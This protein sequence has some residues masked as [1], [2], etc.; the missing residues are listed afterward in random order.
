MPLR[1]AL[2]DALLRIA[3][4]RTAA[5]DDPVLLP[6]R[7][8]SVLVVDDE[9]IVA[10]VP[11]IAAQAPLTRRS[12]LTWGT[13]RVKLDAGTSTAALLRWWESGQDPL[14]LSARAGER[15]LRL[16]SSYHDLWLRVC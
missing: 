15:R 16:T 6:V 10:L 3:G 11:V 14:V 1:T 7:V 12:D 4:S 8:A 5:G 2:V 9:A 13:L